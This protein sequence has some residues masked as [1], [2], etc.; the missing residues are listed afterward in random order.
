MRLTFLGTGT[1][2]GIPVIACD[3]KVCTSTNTK[4]N[5]T[6]SSIYIV[7]DGVKILIDSGPDFRAQML[8]EKLFDVDAILFTHAHRDHI[9]GLDEIRSISFLLKK[10]I[11]LFADRLTTSKI[12]Q[13]F[14]YLFSGNYPG[15]PQTKMTIIE[16]EPFLI[17]NKIKVIPIPALHGGEPVLG[18]R[19]N[20]VTYLTDVNFLPE[21]SFELIKGSKIFII[22]GLQKEKHYSHFNLEEALELI[23]KLNAPTNYLTHIGHFLGTHE[24]VSKELPN[25][26]KLAFDGLVLEL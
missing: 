9:A 13:T 2:T 11:E 4:D 21:K 18:F 17:N 8:R 7:V 26:V 12:L 24:D 15:I 22:T 23:K 3:C 25:N 14:Q 19:I 10:S 5:R 16:E 1:S 6:R 20:D